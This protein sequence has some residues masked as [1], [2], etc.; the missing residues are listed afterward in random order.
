MDHSII[1]VVSIVL[2][3]NKK[4]PPTVK[5]NFIEKVLQ[6]YET[7]AIEYKNDIELQGKDQL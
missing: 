6:A 1:T 5:N 3:F 4:I 7:N 2:S